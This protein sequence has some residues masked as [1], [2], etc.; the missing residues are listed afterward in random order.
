MWTLYVCITVVNGGPLVCELDVLIA[1]L[2][3]SK[4]IP[5]ASKQNAEVI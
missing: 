5:P 2:V 1:Y 3:Y 4:V